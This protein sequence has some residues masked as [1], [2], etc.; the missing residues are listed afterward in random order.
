VGDS[1]AKKI[2]LTV[3]VG[4]ADNF[5]TRADPRPSGCAA[6]SVGSLLD[7]DAPGDDS[8]F[9]TDAN[10]HENISHNGSSGFGGNADSAEVADVAAG[11]TG[12]CTRACRLC[13]R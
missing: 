4:Q 8:V 3:I 12:A 1:T 7:A 5:T 9:G 6:N 10:R 13:G 11:L 2:A